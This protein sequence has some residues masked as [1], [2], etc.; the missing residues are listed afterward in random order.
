MTFNIL[1]LTLR[2]FIAAFSSG[3]TRVTGAANKVLG[4]L[5]VIDLVLLG[6][7]WA[8]DGGDRLSHVFKKLLQ[9]G[10]W[11]WMVQAFPSVAKSLVDSLIQVGQLAGGGAGGVS[12]LMDPSQLAGYGLTATEPLAKKISD[13]GITDAGQLFIFGIS[14]LAILAC[15]FIMAIH[16]FLGVLEYYLIAAVVGIFMPFGLLPSTKFLAE[17]AIGA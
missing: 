10:F 1:T 14:Y 9:I 5:I 2:N 11:I 13:M 6:L 4:A 17:K 3:S 12:L 7:W 15:F 8:L 16:V